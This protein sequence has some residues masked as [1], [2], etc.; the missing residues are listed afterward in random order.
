ME[1]LY[2]ELEMAEIC[3]VLPLQFPV[4]IRVGYKQTT[5]G[6]SFMH[7]YVDS[8][9]YFIGAAVACLQA[10]QVAGPASVA[11]KSEN[12]TT[13]LRHSVHKPPRA[14]RLQFGVGTHG[15]RKPSIYVLR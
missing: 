2:A 15:T 14:G 1:S 10:L 6:F 3:S 8:L 9:P 5:L 4:V 7:N 12:N 13:S 11:R